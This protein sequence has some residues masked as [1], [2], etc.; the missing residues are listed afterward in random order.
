M[1]RMGTK[2]AVNF[3]IA[4][5]VSRFNQEITNRLLDGAKT[6][7]KELDF[8]EH[9]IVTHYV[10]GAIEIPLVVQRL[11]KTHRFEAIVAL[12]C[13]IR[14]ETSHYDYV[15]EFVTHGCMRV[16]LAY[17]TPVIFG[18]L[19]TEDEEQALAR[20]GG[21]HGNKGSESIDAAC[22]MVSVL[23]HIDHHG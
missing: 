15:C 18:V 19:T 10:P 8:S 17:N 3:P 11:A 5:V 20:S 7:L 22:Q 23:R 14:G 6:R 12:G 21:V 13:V 2:P 1:P 16:S 4:I 9:N